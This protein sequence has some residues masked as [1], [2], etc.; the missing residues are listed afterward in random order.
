[1]PICSRPNICEVIRNIS[2][3]CDLERSGFDHRK[4]FDGSIAWLSKFILLPVG[5]FVIEGSS[6][7]LH[8]FEKHSTDGESGSSNGF[9]CDC[10]DGDVVVLCGRYN[11]TGEAMLQTVKVTTHY[12]NNLLSRV[13]SP[14][15][16]SVSN[17]SE[18]IIRCSE[19][20]PYQLC[21]PM[22]ALVPFVWKHLTNGLERS[23]NLRGGGAYKTLRQ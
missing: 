15:E 20:G 14:K 23:R 13:E 12:S 4:V 2:D 7:P 18:W 10:G 1:M 3:I 11:M 21:K 22:P 17:S 8:H 16:E 6:F 19:I 9:D 5:V